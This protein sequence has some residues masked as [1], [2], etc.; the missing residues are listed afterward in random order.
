MALSE[1]NTDE[2]S[3]DS[4]PTGGRQR[5]TTFHNVAKRARIE[6][7]DLEKQDEA[8]LNALIHDLDHHDSDTEIEKE[9]A[10]SNIE[11]AQSR[12]LFETDTT[13]GLSDAEV[14][15]RRRKYGHNRLKEEKENLLIKFC[16][17]FVGPIQFVMEA[18]VTSTPYH[19]TSANKNNRLPQFLLLY[20]SNMSTLV[21]SVLFYY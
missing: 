11:S 5:E 6:N 19:G 9:V 20:S 10:P 17:F 7:I 4:C 1:V 3:S 15:L 21:S 8:D 14:I 12:E 2:N 16:M 13:Q 18:S